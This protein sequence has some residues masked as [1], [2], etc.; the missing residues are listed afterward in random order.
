MDA[1][2]CEILRELNDTLPDEV[3][4]TLSTDLDDNLEKFGVPEEASFDQTGNG[5]E[6]NGKCENS[7]PGT[8]DTF[9]C[10]E[11]LSRNVAET[12]ESVKALLEQEKRKPY[13]L[14]ESCT[15]C[16]IFNPSMSC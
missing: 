7:F 9:E 10:P 4:T 14:L 3:S 11:D 13:C 15:F 16:T 12:E 8:E 1:Q 6:C 5:F 2:D